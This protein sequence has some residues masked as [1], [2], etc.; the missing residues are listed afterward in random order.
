MIKKSEIAPNSIELVFGDKAYKMRKC[1]LTNDQA[2][3]F[4]K[5]SLL[6]NN[7]NQLGKE[8]FMAELTSESEG[9]FMCKL[10]NSRVKACCTYTLHPCALAFLSTI[11]DRPGTAIE[12]IYYI[13]YIVGKVKPHLKTV[14][15]TMNH[16]G[17]DIFP[18]GV[19]SESQLRELWDDQKLIFDDPNDRRGSDNLLDYAVALKSLVG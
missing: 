7:L 6:E 8:N 11:C 9:N 19:F 1:V 17:M 2:E 3:M 5:L 16:I 10:I 4:L 13:Q 18:M 14:E 12:Y 15:I